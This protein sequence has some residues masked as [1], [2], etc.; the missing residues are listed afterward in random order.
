MA[1]LVK[2][3]E[4]MSTALH[5]GSTVDMIWTEIRSVTNLVLCVS[6]VCSQDTGSDHG[7]MNRKAILLICALYSTAQGLTCNQCKTLTPNG[8]C[9]STSVPCTGVCGNVVLTTFLGSETIN[10]NARDCLPPDECQNGSI[11]FGL[12]RVV[13][14]T[15]CCSTDLCNSGSLTLSS[16]TGIAKGCASQSVC[17]QDNM[18]SK[19]GFVNISCCG[20]ILCNGASSIVQNILLLGI[21]FVSYTI[22]Q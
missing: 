4:D 19:L 22:F 16:P 11:N 6:Q 10:L 15:T 5:N 2:L 7:K 9:S 20:G 12:T 14:T 18:V 17:N 13:M 1:Y 8:M 21:V 3:K